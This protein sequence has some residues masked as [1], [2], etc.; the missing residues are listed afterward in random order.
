MLLCF[1]LMTP[2]AQAEEEKVKPIKI[3]YEELR[4]IPERT[5]GLDS[6]ETLENT[7]MEMLSNGGKGLYSWSWT[8][9]LGRANTYLGCGFLDRS[10]DAHSGEYSLLVNPK[11]GEHCYPSIGGVVI[12]GETYELSIWYKRLSDGGNANVQVVFSCRKE[13]VAVSYDRAK[14]TY[15]ST[16]ADGWVQKALRFVAPEYATKATLRIRITGPAEILLDDVSLLCITDEMPKPEMPE[17]KP[18][19]KAIEIE[20]PSFEG[21]VVGQLIDTIPGWGGAIGDARISDEY[22]HTGTK[23]IDLHNVDGG[24]D[25]I[26]IRYLTGLEEGATYQVSS[27]LMNPSDLKI[28]LGYW[29]H[30]CSASE[31]SSD[32]NLSDGLEKPRWSVE[33]N[34]HWT[35]YRAEF[36]VPKGAKSAM[37]YFRHRLAPGSLFMDDVEIYMV[38]APAAT[39]IKTDE[40]FY[41]TEWKT[42]RV[43]V[44]PA[45]IM[46]DPLGAR[47]DFVMTNESG[48][49][50]YEGSVS[51]LSAPV[52]FEF[53]LS[54]MAV[55]G[56]RHTINVKVYGADGTLQQEENLPVFRYDRPTYLGADGVFRKNG[57]EIP[58]I[59]GSG[60]NMNV[61]DRHPEKGGIT[62]AQLVA[63]SPSLG[64]EFEERMD[65]YY[66]QGMFV[67]LNLYS[68]IKSAGHPDMID[69]VKILVERLKD[70]PALFGWKLID[71]P[72]QKGISDEEMIAGYKAVRDIDPNHPIYIDDSPMG[73]YEWLFRYC[74]IFESDHYGGANG[75]AG[76]IMTT[77]IDSAR[78]AS[79]GRK[80][81]SVLLQF[82]PINGYV[83]AINETRHQIYQS[84]FS[85]VT[86]FSYFTLSDSSETNGV[87][88]IDTERWTNIVEKWAPW[89]HDFAVGCFIT[90]EYKFVNYQKT[91]DV[92]W[93]TFTDG[94]DIYAIILNRNKTAPIDACI[95][96]SDGTGILSVGEYSAKSMTGEAKTLKGSGTLDVT[97]APLETVVWKVTPLGT[98]LNVSHLKNSSFR[99]VIYYPW[100]YNAIA[101]LEEKGIVNRVSD[102]WYGPGE[103]ITRGDYAMFLVR[104][105]G[106]TN[107]AGENFQD[108]EADAEYAKELAIG[109]AAGILNGIGDNKFNPEAEST[110]QDMMTMTSRALKLSNS[111]DIS[112]FS[113]NGII[114]EYAASHVSAMVAEGLIKGNADGAINPLGNTTRAEAAVIM[115]RILNR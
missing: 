77:F 93:G 79:G 84:L 106:L 74:D 43:E 87:K 67:M 101:V 68:G 76:R 94:T 85:G 7:G 24:K 109:K 91:E 83:P 57:K 39:R 16:K 27:W 62:V 30:W 107:G 12:P 88:S 111:A 81:F 110:R 103:N 40:T 78:E 56:E 37:L 50:V 63:D 70:H 22:A 65:A 98:S 92:L 80:P 89:E 96:L 102:V 45:Y 49:V 69:Y 21:G 52:S 95:P 51:N 112:S 86:G 114:A 97:L 4:E 41:Y 48:T 11:E 72:Y 20:D 6:Y 64:L 55:K 8:S 14:Q 31:Y 26:G 28:D 42:G 38:K 73:G 100:A 32:A 71:E 19:I 3:Q 59:M 58:F 44:E 75:D 13:G 5:I 9:H 108:V 115:Q 60:L 17:K 90:G 2:T 29:M 61:L 1:G 35:E 18:V 82:S 104:T 105:L 36:V 54:V 23:S 53:P 46:G 47:A 99:D 66:K 113:D 10:T 15:Q 34:F 33:P 25:S